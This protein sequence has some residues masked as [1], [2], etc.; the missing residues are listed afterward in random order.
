MVEIVF[1]KINI[2]Y[3][4]AVPSVLEKVECVVHVYVCPVDPD[5]LVPVRTLLLVAN[6]KEVK[7]LVGDNVCVLEEKN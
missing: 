2:F 7:D 6:A 5:E 1:R 3:L 4:S